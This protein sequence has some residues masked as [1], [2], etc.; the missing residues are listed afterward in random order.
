MMC[1]LDGLFMDFYGTLVHGEPPIEALCRR[2]VAGHR[3]PVTPEQLRTA[4]GERFLARLQVCNHDRFQ[5]IYRINCDTLVECIGSLAGREVDPSPFAAAITDWLRSPPPFD[6]TREVL[7][8]I[9]RRGLRVWIVSNADHDDVLATLKTHSIRVDG[10]VTS[11]S[12]RSYKP[13]AGIFRQA[14]ERTGWFPG[15]VIHTGDS[16]HHDVGGAQS[17]GLRTAWLCRTAPPADLG[18]IRPDHRIADLRD[19]S[20]L[21]A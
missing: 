17:L 9:R 3:L 4:W 16:L 12:A 5:T 21:L 19:L 10:V 11:E 13:H 1:K 2:V 20:P 18:T 7:A 15:R 14:L 6:E 8:E